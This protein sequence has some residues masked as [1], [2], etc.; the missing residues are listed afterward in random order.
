MG[1]EGAEAAK[2]GC[3][4]EWMVPFDSDS[5][6]GF[7]LEPLEV[8]EDSGGVTGALLEIRSGGREVGIEARFWRKGRR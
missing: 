3:R 6:S 5:Q 2:R 4:K 7:R 8:G 1:L